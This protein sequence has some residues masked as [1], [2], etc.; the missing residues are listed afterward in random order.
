MVTSGT[1]E[2]P[3]MAEWTDNNLWFFMREYI[4]A[5][6]M[7]SDDVVLGLA[8]AGT[9]STGYVYPVLARC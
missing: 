7:T 2:L 1:T 4:R 6:E 9:G 5:M 3:R 8:P